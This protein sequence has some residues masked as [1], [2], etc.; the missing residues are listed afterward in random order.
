M[1][2]K[3]GQIAS[4]VRKADVNATKYNV[5]SRCVSCVTDCKNSLYR[6]WQE[7]EIYVDWSCREVKIR[8]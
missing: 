8:R 6:I 2:R 4:Q 1:Q 5:I 7:E 3:R